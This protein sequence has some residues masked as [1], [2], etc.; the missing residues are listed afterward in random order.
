MIKKIILPLQRNQIKELK[1]GD[2]ILLSGVIFTAR[3]QAHKRLAAAI[4]QGKKSPFDLKGAVIYYCGPAPAKRKEAVGSCGPTTSARMDR[5]TPLLLKAG[6]GVMIG[7]GRRSPEVAAT[8]K[9]FKAA[10]LLTYA[11]CGA[12][13]AG[14]VKKKTLIAYPDLGA[15]AIYKLEVNDFPVIVGI[16]ASGKDIYGGKTQWRV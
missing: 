12:L 1:A 16:D 9:K 5:F 7:K 4:K 13:L 15:E 2:K 8:I 11:G 10:Y 6:L 3:D 14:F